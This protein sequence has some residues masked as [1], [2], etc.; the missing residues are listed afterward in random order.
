MAGREADVKEIGE[1][2]AWGRGE[3][4]GRRRGGVNERVGV[5]EDL[6]RDTTSMV[7]AVVTPS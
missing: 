5:V 7:V 1:G 2:R 4:R 3:G 6:C